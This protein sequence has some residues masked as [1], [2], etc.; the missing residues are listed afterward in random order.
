MA[1]KTI[2]PS[3]NSTSRNKH[4][5]STPLVLLHPNDHTCYSFMRRKHKIRTR[6]IRPILVIHGC[7]GRPEKKSDVKGTDASNADLNW[8]ANNA[9]SGDGAIDC[10]RRRDAE[11]ERKTRMQSKLARKEGER[12]GYLVVAVLS[13][14]GFASVAVFAIYCRF[15]HRITVGMEYWARWAHRVLW[16]GSFWSMHKGLGMTVFGISYMFIHD[17][18]VHRRFPVGPI[19]DCPYLQRVSAAH[20]LHHSEKL[21]G[22]PYGL[23]LAPQEIEEVGGQKELEKE[24]NRRSQNPNYR[25]NGNEEVFHGGSLSFFITSQTYQVN[26]IFYG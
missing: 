19:A 10:Q 13:T 3:M 20:Q 22:V 2:P 26:D 12:Y 8:H 17:G 16:H 6:K 1:S 11:E 25:I 14:L 23:F 15:L 4:H 18:L 5:F 24:F 9:E 21:K 7:L